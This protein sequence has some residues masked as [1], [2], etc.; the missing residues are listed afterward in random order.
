MRI[1]ECCAGQIA[2]NLICVLERCI[3]ELRTLQLCIIE[4][5]IIERCPSEPCILQ[6]SIAQIEAAHVAP[7]KIDRRQFD[8]LPRDLRDS[9]AVDNAKRMLDSKPNPL[10]YLWQFVVEPGGG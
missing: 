9:F 1:F 3:F 8:V 6:E 2:M 10:P 4:V 5:S 7:R